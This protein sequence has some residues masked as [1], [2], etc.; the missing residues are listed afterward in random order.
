M[1]PIFFS[2][3][4]FDATFYA[5]PELTPDLYGG[6]D[7]GKGRWLY[8]AAWISAALKAERMGL[9]LRVALV[10]GSP[11]RREGLATII[12]ASGH[13]LVEEAGAADVVLV[14]GEGAGRHGARP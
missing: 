12:R 13:V 5:L 3:E 4:E 10:G 11:T 9:P 8:G 2:G 7:A 1:I 14:D 6:K